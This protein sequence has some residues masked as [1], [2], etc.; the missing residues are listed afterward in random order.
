VE[1]LKLSLSF[2]FKLS[3][4]LLSLLLL[5]EATA[6]SSGFSPLDGLTSSFAFDT[7]LVLLGLLAIDLTLPGFREGFNRL[8]LFHFGTVIQGGCF[9]ANEH[10]HL[11]SSL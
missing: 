4:C 5:A 3:L 9:S 1:S 2:R 8:L 6:S 10:R 11:I 7:A